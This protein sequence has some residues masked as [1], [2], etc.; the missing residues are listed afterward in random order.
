WFSARHLPAGSPSENR[1]NRA[2]NRR[3]ARRQGLTRRPPEARGG[4]EEPQRLTDA[5]HRLSGVCL[6]RVLSYFMAWLSRRTTSSIQGGAKV[7]QG[8]AGWGA[9]PPSYRGW[10]G[11]GAARAASP[12]WCGSDSASDDDDW[13]LA[14]LC[15]V[16][17]AVHLE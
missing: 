4:K 16:A 5:R 10:G 17:A 8:V 2:A 9:P 7:V 3:R 15:R 6:Y 12:R 13:P 11:G 1:R 14:A